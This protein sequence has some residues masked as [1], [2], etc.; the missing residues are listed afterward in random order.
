[1]IDRLLIK[2][3][4]IICPFFLYNTYKRNRL[5]MGVFNKE[6]QIFTPRGKLNAGKRGL[7][8]SVLFSSK[9][10][11]TKNAKI[12]RNIRPFVCKACNS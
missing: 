1:M 3:K 2:K 10:F 6:G 5:P 12:R 11:S 8:N 9:L 7:R 4:T